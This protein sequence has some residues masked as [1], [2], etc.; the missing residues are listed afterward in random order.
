MKIIINRESKTTDG[1]FGHLSLDWN[2]FTCVT[3]ENLELEI[4]AGT[5]PLTFAYSPHFNRTMPLINVPGRTWTWIH[6]ANFPV[7]LKGC[8]AV[9]EKIDGDAIDTSQVEWDDLWKIINMQAGI[10]VQINDITK[11]IT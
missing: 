6:W 9:G 1:I 4:A 8:V 2:S 10:Q 7:Q 11:E 5:Y 3:C